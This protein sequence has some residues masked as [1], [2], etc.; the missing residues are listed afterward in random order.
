M[1]ALLWP[2]G[3]TGARFVVSFPRR[4]LGAWR[5]RESFSDGV[6]LVL[7]V[8]RFGIGSLVFLGCARQA[9]ARTEG[10]EVSQQAVGSLRTDWK[11]SPHLHYPHC[12]E[13]S[14]KHA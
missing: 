9:S 12:Y 7:G 13:A 3:G 14:L 2:W 10:C 8:W 4:S 5:L 6:F 1:R 11:W